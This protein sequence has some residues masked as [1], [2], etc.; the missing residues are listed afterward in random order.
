MTMGDRIAI[1]DD[2]TLQQVGTPLEC[3][4]EPNNLFVAGFIG[5]PSMNFFPVERDGDD[6][7]GDGFR[8]PLSP[9][10]RESVGD[11][12]DLVLGIRPEDIVV[13]TNGDHAYEAVVD[14]VE[15]RGDENT[16]HLRFSGVD[17]GKL[18]TATTGGMVDIDQGVTLDVALP[19]SAIHVFDATT[20]A[21]RHTRELETVSEPEQNAV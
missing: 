5:E 4:H 1:L 7:V 2:G 19:E 12:T 11:A 8:Y 3:Y 21:A 13:G 10:V 9:A 18:F 14:V 6:L 17:D 15:P 20:E 16:V